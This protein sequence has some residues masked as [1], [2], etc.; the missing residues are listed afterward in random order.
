[1]KNYVIIDGVK[2]NT[3]IFK[4]K[5]ACDYSVCK[6]ICCRAAIPDLDLEGGTLTELEYNEV[7]TAKH[8]LSRFCDA[9]CKGSVLINPAYKKDGNCYT[10][11]LK[12]KCLFN[13]LQLGTCALKLAHE[14]GMVSFD[15]PVHCELYPLTKEVIG[16]KTFLEFTNTFGL[17]CKPALDKGKKDGVYVTK[18]CERPIRRLFG[19]EFYKRIEEIQADFY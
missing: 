8:E 5:F 7:M 3:H 10:S 19:D 11:L 12:D 9:D 17:L 2:V 16:K 14:N 4:I 18:F 6:G 15:I 1:M 13:N